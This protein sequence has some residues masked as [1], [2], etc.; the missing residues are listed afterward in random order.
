M[1]ARLQPPCR[2]LH[3]SQ[4]DSSLKHKRKRPRGRGM[5]VARCLEVD[6][7]AVGVVHLHLDQG[8]GVVATLSISDA[9]VV[10]VV[11][12]VGDEALE[13][14]GD[15][16]GGGVDDHGAARVGDVEG[17]LASLED[18]ISKGVVLDQVDDALAVGGDGGGHVVGM[19][20]L[21]VPSVQRVSGGKL[22]EDGMVGRQVANDLVVDTRADALRN[23]GRGAEAERQQGKE[24]GDDGKHLEGGFVG[25]G[26]GF[27]FG[28]GVCGLV[29]KV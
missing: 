5:C 10:D 21:G 22:G 25:F 26:F 23:A 13:G 3:Q 6:P 18:D 4:R 27:G 9:R 1:C 16:G 19:A 29:R 17:V 12:Q 14:E 15:L 11:G 28:F 20:A 7:V 8:V 24:S 2:T